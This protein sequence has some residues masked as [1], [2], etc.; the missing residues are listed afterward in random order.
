VSAAATC[1]FGD[2]RLLLIY[3][4]EVA[5]TNGS[6]SYFVKW[7]GVDSGVIPKTCLVLKYGISTGFIFGSLNCQFLR[8][9]CVRNVN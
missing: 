6:E 1:L 4:F 3:E 9:R 8:T 5:L 7:K 2:E